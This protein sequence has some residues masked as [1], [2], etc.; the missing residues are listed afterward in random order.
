MEQFDQIVHHREL[1]VISAGERGGPDLDS[2]S[3]G[4]L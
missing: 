2:R 4:D 3:L 1:F